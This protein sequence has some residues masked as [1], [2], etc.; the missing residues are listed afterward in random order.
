M[1]GK[2]SRCTELAVLKGRQADLTLAILQILSK[3]AL[4]KYDVHKKILCQGFKETHYGTIKKKM[5]LLEETG[6]LKQAGLRKTQPGNEGILYES[7]FK[8]LAALKLGV[9]NLD[10]LFDYI[11]EVSAMELLAL[12]TRI[13]EK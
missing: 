11:D 7:T 13:N 4:V 8:A 5:K 2:R 3:E 10:N 6:Y 1:A 9:T 12:L